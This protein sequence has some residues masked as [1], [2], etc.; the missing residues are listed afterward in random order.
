MLC[1]IQINVI[2]NFH[3]LTNLEPCQHLSLLWESSHRFILYQSTINKI[4]PKGHSFPTPKLNKSIKVPSA[5][6]FYDTIEHN[7][8]ITHSNNLKIL[9]VMKHTQLLCK[10]IQTF[11]IPKKNVQHILWVTTQGHFPWFSHLETSWPFYQPISIHL[12]KICLYKKCATLTAV[13]HLFQKLT[14]FWSAL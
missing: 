13:C 9:K 2:N 1:H 12:I 10:F 5:L 3:L 14:K 4:I 7:H 8:A 11:Q 6:C